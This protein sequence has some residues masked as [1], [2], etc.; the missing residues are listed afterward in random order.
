VRSIPFAT[1]KLRPG[2]SYTLVEWHHLNIGEQQMLSGLYDEAEVY[3]IFRPSAGVHHLTQKVAYK[4]VA[5]L[6]L[7]L[8]HTNILPRYLCINVESELH[9]TIA[10]LVLDGIL[11]MEDE[12]DFISGIRAVKAIFGETIGAR[13]TIPSRLSTLSTQAIQYAFLLRNLNK[14]PLSY[15]LYTFNTMPWD[16]FARSKFHSGYSVKEFLL[17]SAECNIDSLLHEYW[18][19]DNLSEEKYWL[20]W[21]RPAAERNY[22]IAA[23]KPTFKLYLSPVISDLP[24]VFQDAIPVLTAS[25]AFSF[26]VGSTVRGL[27]RPDKMVAYFAN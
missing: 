1:K 20:S 27:L 22:S 21:W 6:Y 17:S 18:K 23:D 4:E 5:L 9:E 3:G 13:S 11:E 25:A 2:A 10:Q 8:V 26:K 16:E 12:G 24:N 19:F 15:R 14:R 7:H